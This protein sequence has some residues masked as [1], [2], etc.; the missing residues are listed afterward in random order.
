MGAIRLNNYGS[1]YTCRHLRGP[2]SVSHDI[3]SENVVFPH[4]FSDRLDPDERSN[5]KLSN[6]VSPGQ[7][8]DGAEVI[9]LFA[10]FAP[11]VR[12]DLV[13]RDIAAKP[14]QV[15]A[16]IALGDPTVHAVD[17]DDLPGLFGFGK[18]VH[19]LRPR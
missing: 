12:R 16:A 18:R 9:L 19:S 3:H 1:S 10:R 14:Q 5:S 13:Y 4:G 2:S 11:K 15:A 8:E 17:P 6:V 7:L